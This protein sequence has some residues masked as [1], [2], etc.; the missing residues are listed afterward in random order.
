MNLFIILFIYKLSIEFFKVILHSHRFSIF[1]Y[2]LISLYI[3]ISALS[4][5]IVCYDNK[6][7]Y[8]DNYEQQLS[9]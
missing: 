4:L 7:I 8:T 6:N 1:K 9:L 2:L 3:V 5:L